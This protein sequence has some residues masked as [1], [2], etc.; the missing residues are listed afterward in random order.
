[1]CSGD[2]VGGGGRPGQ[3]T[4]RLLCVWCRIVCSARIRFCQCCFCRV[5]QCCMC[6]CPNIVVVV[7]SV[8]C[9]VQRL[10]T[11]LNIETTPAL[12]SPPTCLEA[13]EGLYL[14][15]AFHCGSLPLCASFVLT[16]T[17]RAC[18][19]GFSQWWRGFTGK[20]GSRS[21]QA[22]AQAMP[23][24]V[25]E[26]WSSCLQDFSLLVLGCSEWRQTRSST[27]HRAPASVHAS[28][29]IKSR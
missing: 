26:L 13:H 1:M 18:T 21:A 22:I 25:G 2:D 6:S 9:G 8:V 4:V 23:K 17:S 29:Q 12:P 14:T 16:G 27:Y 3:G 5:C 24:V 28:R 7:Y 10:C 15:L 11:A 20:S 19:V